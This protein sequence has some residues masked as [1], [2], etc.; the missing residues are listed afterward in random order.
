MVPSI[1]PLLEVLKQGAPSS[2]LVVADKAALRKAAYQL[3]E[4][5]KHGGL[6]WC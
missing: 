3:S 2:G 5:C 4:I 1:A 6:L